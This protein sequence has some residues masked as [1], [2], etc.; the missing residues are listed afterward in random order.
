MRRSLASALA[1]ALL[2]GSSVAHGIT[3]F[4]APTA[5]ENDAEWTN[6]LALADLDGDGD[7][8]LVGPNCGGFFSNPVAQPLR[9]YA[10]DASGAFGE[11]TSMA[12]GAPVTAAIRVVAIADVDG[13]GDLDIYAPSA[14]GSLDTLWINGGGGTFTNEAS[15]R[16]PV[17]LSSH[18]AGARFGDVDGDG[19]LD[20]FV[21]SGY[22]F[23]DTPLARLYLNDGTGTFSDASSNL[24]AAAPVGQDPDDV[25][26]FDADGD[27]DLDVLLNAHTGKSWLWLN[28]G[29]GT[30]TDATSQL[31]AP[32]DM[33]YH[34]GPSACD[35]D[36]DGDLDLWIDNIGPSFTEQLLINDG[37]GSFS[38][39][40]AMRVTSNPIGADDNGVVC[41]DVDG[42]GDFDAIVVSLTDEE[43]V[44]LNDGSGNFAHEPSSFPAIGDR[45][46]W[47]DVGD[48]NGDGRLDVVTGQGEPAAVNRVYLGNANVPVDVR[49]PTVR[50][51]DTP[52][53][54]ADGSAAVL[55]F[56]LEDEAVTDLGPRLLRAFLRV[57]VNGAAATDIDATFVGGDLFRAVVPAT[58]A[59][60]TL[61]VEYCA[62]DRA[63]NTYCGGAGSGGSGGAGPAG[64]GGAG[65]SGAGGSSAA[66]GGQAG[67]PL[68]TGDGCGCRSAGRG[69]SRGWAIVALALIAIARPRG[70]GAATG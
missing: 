37:S 29:N 10:N 14:A 45:T 59:G 25:D 38:D 18:S 55:R 7:L 56:A 6:Y 43:R 22:A 65:P 33:Q 35:V 70:K 60:A 1:L 57:S 51:A 11:V 48:V 8:D 40:T 46:L 66:G 64:S 53:A 68:D 2:L 49:A 5:I 17:S 9:I 13:D 12:L 42:D 30:F 34:Y 50:A 31:P 3:F 24:P 36:D 62:I 67:A 20:L 63:G 47:M 28:A 61:D 54:V 52:P 26:L 23:S 41:A 39:Q 19:D 32:A 4:G 44:L 27:F 16:L 21:A 69:G 58:T 15:T